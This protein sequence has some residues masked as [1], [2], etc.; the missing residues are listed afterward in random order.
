M[1][2]PTFIIH[3]YNVT[4]RG[5]LDWENF[6]TAHYLSDSKKKILIPLVRRVNLRIG[7]KIKSVFE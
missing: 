1:Y 6:K 3:K 5:Y 7:T 2:L 4:T